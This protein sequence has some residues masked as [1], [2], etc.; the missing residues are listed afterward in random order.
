MQ[1]VAA[2]G[3]ALAE[4]LLGHGAQVLSRQL[5]EGLPD[6]WQ[7]V[8]VLCPQDPLLHVAG[9]PV[10]GVWRQRVS[11]ASD[12]LGKAWANSAHPTVAP[13]TRAL[14]SH[15]SIIH[16]AGSILLPA[17]LCPQG[18]DCP[19]ATSFA[20]GS[21]I[22]PFAAP[23]APCTTPDDTEHFEGA[24]G[25]ACTNPSTSRGCLR[26]GSD[27][28][29][30]T[31][32]RCPVAAIPQGTQSWASPAPLAPSPMPSSGTISWLQAVPNPTLIRPFLTSQGKWDREKDNKSRAVCS[33]LP[34]TLPEMRARPEG[35][36]VTMSWEGKGPPAQGRGRAQHHLAAFRHLS[37]SVTPAGSHWHPTPSTGLCTKLC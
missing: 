22:Q 34:R 19:L 11:M 16:Q 3:R 8:L 4:L 29:R 17:C 2:G 31:P 5:L 1:D 32:Q 37:G 26:H 14:L 7:P 18:Q 20:L 23:L 35:T 21:L 15:C 6:L 30:R 36:S 33:L 10:R 27:A 13:G 12:S 9:A 28:P 24:G 25:R